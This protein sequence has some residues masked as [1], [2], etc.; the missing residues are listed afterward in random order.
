MNQATGIN[1]LILYSNSIYESLGIEDPKSYTVNMGF[2]NII[3][4][5]VASL[6]V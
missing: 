6:I 4:G 5:V 1:F 3:G 2:M